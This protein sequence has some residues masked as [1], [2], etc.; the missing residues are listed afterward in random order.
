[1]R[2]AKL[3]ATIFVTALAV[4]CAAD[5]TDREF[6]V[7]AAPGDQPWTSDDITCVTDDHC[8]TG[9]FCGENGVCQMLR[10][11]GSYDSLAPMGLN[12]YFGV[13]AEL[14][15]IS[16]A[17]Y[18][19]GFEAA[20]GSYMSSWNIADARIVDVAG[21]DMT[22][23]RP[24]SIAVATESSD[25]IIVRGGETQ[26]TL[27]VGIWPRAIAA[28]DTDADGLDE[29]VA[30]SDDGTI[31]L[32]DVETES[33]QV[34]M[35]EGAEGKDVAVADVDG[36]GYHEP[37]FLFENSDSTELVVWNVD[38]ELT[39]QDEAY[40]WVFPFGIKSIAAADVDGDLVAEVLCL[41]DGGWFGLASD[42][43]HVFSPARE[44]L[45]AEKSISKHASD[46]AAGDR[47]SDGRAEVAVL[48][49]D[50]KFEI[51]VTD[52]AGQL[53]SIGTWDVTVGEE[54]QRVSM[55]DWDGDSASARATSG[56]A[57]VSGREVP[58]MVMLFPPYP[59]GA[60]N[61]PLNASVGMGNSES[62]SESF[63]DTVSLSV[64]M[65][66][67]FG[68]DF[69]SI[70]KAKVGAFFNYDVSVTQT[71]SQ[72]MSIGA[73]YSAMAAPDVHGT[74]YAAVMLS[75]GCYH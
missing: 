10:C 24:Q 63:S 5:E 67:S 19:D 49:S 16:D 48:R 17:S 12:H 4:G 31:S 46:L 59:R 75:C 54:A 64:G 2:N 62:S 61:A 29:L 1:M 47:D 7:T 34:A 42:K 26:T 39:G 56:P 65:A 3:L 68:A 33:C 51:L 44:E 66:V 70:A 41:E 14:A 52:E 27:S 58:T 8:A 37:I 36:D 22:G 15:I 69:G 18:V 6:E 40:G 21:G 13:D 35:I 9:E 28:G 20:D 60:A 45:V 50:Q 43:I 32:C 23:F 11:D 30:F 74:D 25:E 57:L 53:D 71:V 72:Q 38:A 55:L 73:R